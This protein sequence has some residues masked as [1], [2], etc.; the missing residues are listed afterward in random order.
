MHS[1]TL[2]KVV[3][4]LYTILP[5]FDEKTHLQRQEMIKLLIKKRN[6]RTN[7]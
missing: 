5:S 7:Q 2:D 4:I 3:I 1:S 6:Q